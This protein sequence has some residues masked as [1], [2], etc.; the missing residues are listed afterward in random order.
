[1]KVLVTG[2]HGRPGSMLRRFSAVR[3]DC[4][5]GECVVRGK[6]CYR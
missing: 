3:V 4:V 1:M 5:A 2:S 6:G